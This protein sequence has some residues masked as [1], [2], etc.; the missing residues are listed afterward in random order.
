MQELDS[1]GLAARVAVELMLAC[2]GESGVDEENKVF[3]PYTLFARLPG[4]ITA[5]NPLSNDRIPP[6]E[7]RH[8]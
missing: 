3:P 2:T 7:W 4:P 6:G 8:D 1:E 5:S